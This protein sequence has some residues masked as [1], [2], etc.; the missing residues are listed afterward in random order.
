MIIK[1]RKKSLK[2]RKTFRGWRVWTLIYW[3]GRV[4]IDLNLIRV[5]FTWRWNRETVLS[6]NPLWF[7]V[8]LNCWLNYDRVSVTKLTCEKQPPS[9]TAP[10]HPSNLPEDA[11]PRIRPIKSHY[12]NTE[13]VGAKGTDLLECLHVSFS[14]M[15]AVHVG[16]TS[17]EFNP[18]ISVKI[19]QCCW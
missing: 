17:A 10:Q 3:L 19:N 1:H 11:S 15:K 7:S 13:K 14:G 12:L 5:V 8:S 18:H 6:I 4:H 9:T 2:C 16:W